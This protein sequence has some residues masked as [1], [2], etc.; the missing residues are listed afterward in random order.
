MGWAG[1]IYGE[2]PPVNVY[3]EGSP[4]SLSYE[5]Q[6]ES[7]SGTRLIVTTVFTIT[8]QIITLNFG[9]QVPNGQYVLPR[10][11]QN[12][13]SNIFKEVKLLPH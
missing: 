13:T 5:A 3:V 4:N 1:D 2:L 12:L 10:A 7:L 9:S 8:D 11:L 6:I